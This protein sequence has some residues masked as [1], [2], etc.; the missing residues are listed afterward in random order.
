M[1]R[2]SRRPRRRPDAPRS[3]RHRLGLGLAPRAGRWTMRALTGA[4]LSFLLIVGLGPILWMLKSSITPT[5][6]TLRSRW[7]CGPTASTWPFATAW[8]TDH[9]DRYL[10]NTVVIAFGSWATQLIVATTAGFAL[11]VLRPRGARLLTGLML[12]TLFV[13]PIVLL[14]PLY[15]TD[16]GRADLSSA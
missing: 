3:R 6:D 13:P 15:L 8:N 4:T 14:V 11:S 5:H 10:G 12:A 1:T 7:P 16:R 2:G 9:I